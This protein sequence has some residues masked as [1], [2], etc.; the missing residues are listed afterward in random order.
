MAATDWIAGY[1]FTVLIQGVQYP[2]ARA[3][4][5]PSA[6][7]INRSNSKYSPGF[8]INKAG[9]KSLTFT[10][11]GPYKEGELPIGIGNEYTWTYK[12][13]GANLGFIFLGVVE[14]ITHANDVEDGPTM[15]I[16][17]QNSQDF[18]VLVG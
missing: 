10:A 15:E 9:I 4:Y 5:K 17:V 14:T 18:G 7:M 12:P 2:F 13:S 6:K 1:E 16:T 8:V 3:S 11:S